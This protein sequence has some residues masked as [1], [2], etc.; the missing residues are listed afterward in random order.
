MNTKEKQIDA[1]K[2]EF[3]IKLNNDI[4]I[5]RFF[6]V[7]NYNE[8]ARNSMELYEYLNEVKD[9]LKTQLWRKTSE[10]MLENQ[11]MIMDDPNIMNTSKTEAPEWFHV[12]IKVGEQTICHTG[13][14]A[15]PYPPK[16]RYTMDIRPVVKSMLLEL[17]DIFSGENFSKKYLNYNLG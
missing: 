4:V 9:V 6:N 8:D 11:D 5:Q 16:T 13:F 10:Y 15:K 2:M 3:L 12:I 14:D 17:T 7:K 1:T